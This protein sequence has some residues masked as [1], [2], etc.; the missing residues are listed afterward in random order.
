MDF[1][2]QA[3]LDLKDI[4]LI[5]KGGSSLEKGI[6][7]LFKRYHQPFLQY[8]RRTGRDEASAED[9]VQDVFVK[10]VRKID[11]FRGDS[12]LGPWLWTVVKRTGYDKRI[13]PRETATEDDVLEFIIGGEDVKDDDVSNC[14]RN[15]FNQYAKEQNERAQVLTLISFNG[16][17]IAEI[18]QFI[19]RTPGATREYVSQ[20]RK[21]LKPFI[22][23]CLDLL[24]VA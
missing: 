7:N 14:V 23:H 5:Q 24:V 4:K 13:T 16:W 19:D 10:L 9:L 17:D 11:S 1:E 22:E 18:A 2:E 12:P 3:R 8:Y 15:G 20:C 6:S 21:K